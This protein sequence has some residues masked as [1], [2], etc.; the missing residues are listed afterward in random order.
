MTKRKWAK[1][2]GSQ[3]WRNRAAHQMRTEPLCRY[4]Q[5][6]GKLTPAEVADHI[7]PHHGDSVAFF[8]GELQSLCKPHHDSS[9]H[10]L[11]A[12]GYDTRIGEDGMP[13]DPKHPYYTGKLPRPPRADAKRHRSPR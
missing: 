6:E 10:R 5:Q 12:R 8:T 11:E 4:C 13:L 7:T 2:Y 1:L 3:H 9:K